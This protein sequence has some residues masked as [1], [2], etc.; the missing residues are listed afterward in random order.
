M[1]LI[2]I[3]NIIKYICKV[4]HTARII[5]LWR[6]LCK[7]SPLNLVKV[8]FSENNADV[9]ELNGLILGTLID[10]YTCMEGLHNARIITLT[11]FL[12]NTVRY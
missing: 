8:L 9:F 4:L 12:S 5:T 6:L 1:E 3:W 2:D 10:I 7:L 11:Y